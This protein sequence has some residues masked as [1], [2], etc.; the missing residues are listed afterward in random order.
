MA[1]CAGLAVPPFPFNVT[2]P[3]SPLDL[4]PEEF[5][6]AANQAVNIVAQYFREIASKPVM[7]VTTAAA[8]RDLLYEPLPQHASSI[9]DALATVRDVIYPLSRH[10]GHPRFFGYVA[11]PGTPAAAIADLLT[12]GLNANLTSWR[13]APAATEME[14]LVINW[15]KAM[16]GFPPASSGLLVSGGSIA[17]FCGL[18]AARSAA[19]PTISRSGC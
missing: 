3:A 2:S 9:E 19:D 1:S 7:P 13:S 4:A 5:H 16:I 11:S 6:L 8:I 18:A 10:N 15:L 14:H 17:N 12:A